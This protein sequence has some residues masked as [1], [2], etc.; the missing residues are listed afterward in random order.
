MKNNTEFA[1]ASDSPVA[2]GFIF[3]NVCAINGKV[4]KIYKYMN[5][6]LHRNVEAPFVAVRMIKFV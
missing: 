5:L 4:C 1:V 6:R 3:R 2:D